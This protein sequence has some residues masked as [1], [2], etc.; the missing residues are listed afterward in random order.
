V[1][2]SAGYD[3]QAAAAW[4]TVLA[5]TDDVPELYEWLGEALMRKQ[6]YAEARP[7]LKDAVERWPSDTRFARPLALLYAA[8]GEA[9]NA[10]QARAQFLILQW[11]FT[12]HRAGAAVHGQAED[13]KLARG[14]AERYLATKEP[15][16]PLVREWLAFLEKEAK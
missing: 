4:Q 1:F 14:Y 10:V 15:N 13:L 5:R 3:T 9:G 12:I 6:L 16:Q 2:A 7:I 8:G 11:L